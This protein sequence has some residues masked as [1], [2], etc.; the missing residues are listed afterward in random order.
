MYDILLG[1][2]WQFDKSVVHDG[3][4]NTY[5]FQKYGICHTF[6]PLQEEGTT[7]SSD[8]KE[9]F[10]SGKV[11]L[12][13]MEEEEVSYVIVFKPIII[14]IAAAITDLPL[15]IQDILNEHSDI[16]MDDL[17]KE[18][19]PV[20]SISHHIDLIAGETLPNK[21]AYGMTPKENEEIRKQVQELLDKGLIKESHNPCVMP[22]VLSLKKDGGWRMC[23]DCRAMNKITI[24][25]EFPMPCI[26][27]LLHC[28]S[29][30]RWVS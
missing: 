18:L 1:S 5:K 28:L 30:A 23:I 21:A 6:L 13:Q 7:N 25:Y 11:F 9:L 19:S 14:L 10:L 26:D 20:R 17:P 15:K 27:D 3:K 8:S 29:S 12:Q 2:P 16:I 22:T 4:R 24:R